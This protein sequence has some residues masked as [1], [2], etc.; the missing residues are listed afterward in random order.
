MGGYYNIRRIY[1]V[2]NNNVGKI[3]YKLFNHLIIGY[4]PYALSVII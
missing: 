4:E 2:L 1:V 3:D